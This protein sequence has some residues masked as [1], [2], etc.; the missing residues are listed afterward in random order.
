MT[1]RN[2]IDACSLLALCALSCGRAQGPAEAPA[3]QAPAR[4]SDIAPRA[5]PGEAAPAPAQAANSTSARDMTASFGVGQYYNVYGVAADDTLNVRREPGASAPQIAKLNPGHAAVL[6][7]G[8]SSAAET[9]T[10]WRIATPGVEGWVNARFLKPAT[11]AVSEPPTLLC[12]GNEP[13]W[14][15]HVLPNGEAKCEETCKG[16]DGLRATL[17]PQGTNQWSVK[18]TK[19]DATS[20]LAGTIE[21]QACSDGMS[22]F[23]HL[24]SVRLKGVGDASYA[25]CCRLTL[26]TAQAPK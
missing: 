11:A 2:R 15:L 12:F 25:G 3:A 7:T 26:P 14:A 5:A 22:D 17:D 21:K 19:P 20:F 16:P 24:F 1:L 6:W 13:F 8:T 9:S 18:V 4:G 23:K 10:W